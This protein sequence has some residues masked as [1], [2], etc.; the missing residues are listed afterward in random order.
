MH[1]K[2]KYILYIIDYLYVLLGSVNG[3]HFP[4][5]LVR[6]WFVWCLL[7]IQ[8]EDEG[9]KWHS[10]QP[11]Q[12][13]TPTKLAHRSK[14]CRIH[15]DSESLAIRSRKVAM[16]F[17]CLKGIPGR[18]VASSD[19]C[20]KPRL[21]PKGLQYTSRS[22][23]VTS[24]GVGWYRAWDQKSLAFIDDLENN[25]SMFGKNNSIRL[26]NKEPSGANPKIGPAKSQV[27]I[28]SREQKDSLETI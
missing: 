5:P 21:W 22:L 15:P 4:F 14:T 13:P 27:T 19:M 9:H 8:S 1:S 2:L 23:R 6:V 20:V 12:A 16:P 7:W 3:S 11:H 24:C 28:F 17:Q 10:S 25:S 18:Q 26:L